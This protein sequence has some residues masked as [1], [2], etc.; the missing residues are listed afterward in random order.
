MG[1]RIFVLLTSFISLGW[2]GWHKYDVNKTSGGGARAYGKTVGQPKHNASKHQSHEGPRSFDTY[3]TPTPPPPERNFHAPLKGKKRKKFIKN[4]V[5]LQGLGN[6]KKDKK[7][8]SPCLKQKSMVFFPKHSQDT[9]PNNLPHSFNI[10]DLDKKNRSGPASRNVAGVTIDL[11]DI[12]FKH[13][14]FVPGD[15]ARWCSPKS[16]KIKRK[17]VPVKVSFSSQDTKKVWILQGIEGMAH[18]VSAGGSV[19]MLTLPSG[20][21]FSSLGLWGGVALGQFF[22]QQGEKLSLQHTYLTKSYDMDERYFRRYEVWDTV[23]NAF[24]LGAVFPLQHIYSQYG[25]DALHAPFLSSGLN[26]LS[27]LCV[28]PKI[29]YKRKA[30]AH[31]TRIQNSFSPKKYQAWMKGPSGLDCMTKLSLGLDVVGGTAIIGT[32]GLSYVLEQ[33]VC[34]MVSALECAGLVG[35]FTSFFGRFQFLYERL[36]VKVAIENQDMKGIPWSLTPC[37]IWGCMAQVFQNSAQ[38]YT[39]AYP[40]AESCDQP[41]HI[42]LGLLGVGFLAYF[43]Y[44]YTQNFFN[45]SVNTE[46]Q[47]W[48]KEQM[49]ESS[50]P[51]VPRVN[52]F[53]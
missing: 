23:Q 3:K 22:L 6:L 16:G 19:A 12:Q 9:S 50:F 2:G 42:F 15:G 13:T 24:T 47:R 35:L 51:Q 26:L 25:N 46:K 30:L 33:D 10:L 8:P 43:G 36:L 1:I 20:A 4:L 18:L 17:K 28:V 11:T 21:A 37:L 29:Y 32:Y 7:E 14:N 52:S 49:L 48:K 5:S 39:I 53:S 44:L 31:P 45:D 41:N 38:V 27:F 40:Q 34:F